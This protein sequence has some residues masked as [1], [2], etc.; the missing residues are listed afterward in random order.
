[1]D[2]KKILDQLMEMSNSIPEFEE[3]NNL[4]AWCEWCEN[5]RKLASTEGCRTCE[6]RKRLIE[7]CKKHKIDVVIEE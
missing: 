3:I 6:D 5:T 4:C 1:M 2:M 7:L